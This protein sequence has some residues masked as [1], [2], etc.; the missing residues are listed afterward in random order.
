MPFRENHDTD[1]LRCRAVSVDDFVTVNS[2]MV[3][4]PETIQ[5]RASLLI[6]FYLCSGVQ[7]DS[8]PKGFGPS[9]LRRTQPSVFARK[10]S[11]CGNQLQ[12]IIL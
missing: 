3:S 10:I 9:S 6:P 8:G 2:R 5:K 12:A 4:N 11:V 7:C 1:R